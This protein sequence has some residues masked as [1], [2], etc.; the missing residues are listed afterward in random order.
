M[1]PIGKPLI[2]LG[3]GGHAKVTIDVARR[4]GREVT[5][6]LSKMEPAEHGPLGV[7]VLGGDERLEDLTFLSA[8]DF[9]VAVGSRHVR[10]RLAKL[11]LERG[12]VLAT[13]VHPDAVLEQKLR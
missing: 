3:A 6:L 12:A 10:R 2:L 9:F 7:P 8:H 4:S 5:G 13:L 1:T 11:L